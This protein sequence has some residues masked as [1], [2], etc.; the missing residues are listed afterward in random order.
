MC[1]G[2]LKKQASLYT[3]L[4]CQAQGC[5][6]LRSGLDRIC[7]GVEQHLGNLSMTS[8]Y[9]SSQKKGGFS[10]QIMTMH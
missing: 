5:P 1:L 6:A 10:H 4:C 2:L 3:H 8:L 7:S 9:D